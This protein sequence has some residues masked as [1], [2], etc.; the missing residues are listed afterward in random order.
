MLLTMLA[1]P[2]QAYTEV[3]PIKINEAS[4]QSRVYGIVTL[5]SKP[6]MNQ[7]LWKYLSGIGTQPTL[8]N[9]WTLC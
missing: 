7:E 2:M 5:A 1:Y 8:V 6:E 9:G 4:S 3:S